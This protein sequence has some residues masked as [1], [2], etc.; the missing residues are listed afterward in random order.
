MGLETRLT[1]KRL[2][3]GSGARVLACALTLLL[4]GAVRAGAED[5]LVEAARNRNRDAV[6]TLL[7]QD[8]DVN[9]PQSDGATALLTPIAWPPFATPSHA[10]AS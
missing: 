2:D 10:S 7:K 9:A 4:I 5:R 3:W 1:P 6:R 8:P